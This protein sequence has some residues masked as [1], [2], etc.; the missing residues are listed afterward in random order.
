MSIEQRAE[1]QR[2]PA[3]SECALFAALQLSP[4]RGN[5]SATLDV[6]DGQEVGCRVARRQY[7]PPGGTRGRAALLPSAC[8]CICMALH[9]HLTI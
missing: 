8:I 7:L 9:V 1:R 3:I 2:S 6:T 4:L 5:G